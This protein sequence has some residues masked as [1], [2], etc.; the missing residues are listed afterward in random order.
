M[1]GETFLSLYKKKSALSKT[2]DN[3]PTCVPSARKRTHSHVE[4]KV[5]TTTR[6]PA[7]T[8]RGHT[9]TYESALT[10]SE[11]TQWSLAF[12][13]RL[14]WRIEPVLLPSSVRLRASSNAAVGLVMCA[15]HSACRTEALVSICR[16]HIGS[17]FASLLMH[18][19]CKVDRFVQHYILVI[20]VPPTPLPRRLFRCPDKLHASPHPRE[21]P[22]QDLPESACTILKSR[23]S[24]SGMGLPVTDAEVIRSSILLDSTAALGCCEE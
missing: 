11:V 6:R 10:V 4:G 14:R 9:E 22:C 3:V 1:S 23:F 12:R 7:H 17:A 24:K 18:P 16:H 15:S 21:V 20:Q 13:F 19:L 5:K 2:F 8:V